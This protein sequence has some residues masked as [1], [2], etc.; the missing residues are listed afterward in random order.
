M[1]LS[2]SAARKSPNGRLEGKRESCRAVGPRP[3]PSCAIDLLRPCALPLCIVSRALESSIGDEQKERG[4]GE[5]RSLLVPSSLSSSL[6][7]R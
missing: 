3:R 4:E 7:Q 1:C 6:A 5:V 2:C